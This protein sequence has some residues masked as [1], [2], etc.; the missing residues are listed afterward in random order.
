MF[1]EC[2]FPYFKIYK[3]NTCGTID[4]CGYTFQLNQTLPLFVTTNSYALN[5]NLGYNKINISIP[6]TIK[7]GSI[8][9]VQYN[10]TG[11]L[12]VQNN[13]SLMYSDYYITNSKTLVKLDSTTNT[14]V[15]LNALVDDLYYYKLIPISRSYPISGTYNIS[16]SIVKP[17]LAS[18]IVR[19][20]YVTNSK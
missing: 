17:N 18:K 16:T 19:S 8:L 10:S 3:F 15:Y 20:F 9:V 5:A 13:K 7:K 12:A 14:G 6:I 2:T 1:L 11:R 4:S